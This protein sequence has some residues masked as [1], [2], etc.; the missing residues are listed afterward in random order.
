MARLSRILIKWNCVHQSMILTMEWDT[1]PTYKYTISR[2]YPVELKLKFFE[3][4]NG[5]VFG[6]VSFADVSMTRSLL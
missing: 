1:K 2:Y 5:G 3:F 4:L 6:K